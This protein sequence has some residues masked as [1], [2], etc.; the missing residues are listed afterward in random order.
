[1]ERSQ[2]RRRILTLALAALSV[3]REKISEEIASLESQL[4]RKYRS[5]GTRSGRISA[6]GRKAIADAQ[7]RRWAQFRAA[8]KSA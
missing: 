8:K 2:Q 7:R 6:S 5:S 3:E 4:G 1:M